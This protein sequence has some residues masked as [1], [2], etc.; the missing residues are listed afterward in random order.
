MFREDAKCRAFRCLVNGGDDV[1]GNW[2]AV[3]RRFEQGTSREKVAHLFET[4]TP[5]V[6]TPRAPLAF[7]LRHEI[8]VIVLA[9]MRETLEER[10]ESSVPTEGCH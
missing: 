9:E 10:M 7:N 4:S 2:E 1:G 6:I 5:A 8:D 3:G